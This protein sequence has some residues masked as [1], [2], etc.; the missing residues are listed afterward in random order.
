[1]EREFIFKTENGTFKNGDRV[2]AEC[3]DGGRRVEY[4]GE[5]TGFSDNYCEINNSVVV[6]KGFIRHKS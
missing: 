1:M 5:L 3:M 6:Y 4:D 2:V